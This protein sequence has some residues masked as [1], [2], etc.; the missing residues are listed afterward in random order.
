MPGRE[1]RAACSS[2]MSAAR[3]VTACCGRFLLPHPGRPPMWA[4][5][6]RPFAAADV[7]LHQ[8]DLRR[9]ARR[10][11]CRR[12][13][14]A[15][16]AL[17][18]GRPSPAAAARDSGR[19]RAPGGRPGRPRAARESCRSPGPAGGAWCGRRSARWNSSPPLTSTDPLAARGGSRPRSRPT[20]NAAGLSADS[21]VPANISPSRS[22]S[23]SVWQTTNT[24]CPPLSCVELVADLA[25]L[26]AEA[27]DRF[28]LQVGR[29]FPATRPARR[30]R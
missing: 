26:A 16:G 1:P 7:F 28:D 24:S 30:R 19:C 25:D 10:S 11:S 18:P 8:L 22:T 14:R 20:G 3:S 15:P 12:G 6:G 21:C 27:L 2:S 9:W 5:A 29:S 4:S 23:A 17:R 13:T